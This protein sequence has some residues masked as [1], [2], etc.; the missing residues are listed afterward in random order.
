TPSIFARLPLS[1]PES[2][3]S[4]HRILRR[5]FRQHVYHVRPFRER[6]VVMGFGRIWC[7]D[8]HSSELL[9]EPVPIAGSRPLVLCRTDKG[10]YYG[11]YGRNPARKPMRVMFSEDG[12]RWQVIHELAGVRHIHGIF[13]DPYTDSLWMTTGDDDGECGI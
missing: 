4:C 1:Q 3:A 8:R 5:F 10:L 6:L 2:A 9:G 11:E 7:L 13:H 12:L